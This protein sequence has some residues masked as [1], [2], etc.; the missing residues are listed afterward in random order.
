MTDEENYRSDLV[1]QIC[2]AELALDVAHTAL[3]VACT[4]LDDFDRQA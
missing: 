2:A 4:A 3:D 1:A